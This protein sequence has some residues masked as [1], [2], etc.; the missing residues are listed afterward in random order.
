M[1]PST[2]TSL[3]AFDLSA[4]HFTNTFTFREISFFRDSRSIV[5]WTPSPIERLAESTNAPKITP[6]VVRIV[7]SFCCHNAARGMTSK[8]FSR[9]E[10][11]PRLS[12]FNVDKTVVA[13]RW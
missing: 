9:T 7:R 1:L 3:R 8:S 5:C 10:P 6:S 12:C 13:G 11:L 4:F 2:F